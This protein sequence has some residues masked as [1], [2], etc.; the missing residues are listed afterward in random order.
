MSYH[1]DVVSIS[2][3]AFIQMLI[4]KASQYRFGYDREVVVGGVRSSEVG[5]MVERPEEDIGAL[6]DDR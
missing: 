6:V 5:G 4:N 2:K 3:N 1:A